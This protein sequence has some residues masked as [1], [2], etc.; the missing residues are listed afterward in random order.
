MSVVAGA[1]RFPVIRAKADG[2]IE[3]R[4]N[5]A[6][7]AACTR[8]M[9]RGDETAWVNFHREYSGR[10]HRYLLVLLKGDDE[11]ASE[12]LQV[13]FTRIARHMREF[14]DEAVL[15][16]WVTRIA[17]TALIDEWRKRGRREESLR[18]L[19][20][21]STSTESEPDDWSELL[22]RALKQM[23]DRDRELLQRKYLEGQSVRE[24]ATSGSDSEK[25][26]E[27]RITRARGKL[28]AL[29]LQLLRHEKQDA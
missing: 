22:Q 5:H 12:I 26:V 2:S 20:Q 11:V 25:A 8:A 24:I 29:M 3:T 27:S 7:V 10:I 19:A 1:Q 21:D 9:V 6:E 18:E 23:D 16:H 14:N 28:R 15:W 13:T 17:R 4:P